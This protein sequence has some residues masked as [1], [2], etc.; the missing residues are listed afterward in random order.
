MNPK[1]PNGPAAAIAKRKPP[2]VIRAGYAW[3]KVK[4][5]FTDVSSGVAGDSA[6][7]SPKRANAPTMRETAKSSKL[8]AMRWL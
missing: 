3:M 4:R 5:A 8:P 7:A 6:I 2:I 1:N